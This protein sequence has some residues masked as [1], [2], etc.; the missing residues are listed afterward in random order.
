MAPWLSALRGSLLGDS[1]EGHGTLSVPLPSVARQWSCR[2]R[3][4]VS[5]Q[6]HRWVHKKDTSVYFTTFHLTVEVFTA[7][8][9][10][11]KL[12]LGNT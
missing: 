10:L 5:F 3:P 7:C 12:I 2:K 1:S 4:Q 6:E 11:I 8:I 9:N